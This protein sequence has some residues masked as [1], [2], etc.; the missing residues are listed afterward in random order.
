M[1]LT[2]TTLFGWLFLKSVVH[3]PDGYAIDAGRDSPSYAMG[4][5]RNN[6]VSVDIPTTAIVKGGSLQLRFNSE[7]RA[8]GSDGDELM[9]RFKVKY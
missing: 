6:I 1:V 4:V 3:F 8:F 9:L 5:D 7:D 2:T